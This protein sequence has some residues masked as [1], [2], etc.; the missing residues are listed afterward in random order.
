MWIVKKISDLYRNRFKSFQDL[1]V[2][3]GCVVGIPLAIILVLTGIAAI[4][5]T[6]GTSLLPAL[7]GT[8]L[9]VLLVTGSCASAGNY[10]G[11]SIDSM[12]K[13][14]PLTNAK[15]ATI[16]G[17]IIGVALSIVA[18]PLGFVGVPFI[19]EKATIPLWTLF[20]C[21]VPLTVGRFG[22]ACSYIG[23]AVDTAVGTLANFFRK[24]PPSTSSNSIPLNKE[25]IRMSSSKKMQRSQS[26]SD[27]YSRIRPSNSGSD[28][29][30]RPVAGDAS[31]DR[32]EKI[33]RL[34]EENRRLH[35][36]LGF[37]PNPSQTL[38]GSSVAGELS[39]RRRGFSFSS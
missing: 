26:M 23:R 9:F 19:V 24:K 39:Y 4:P 34:K 28:S 16:A 21:F 6:G 32:E 36:G 37:F 25:K 30:S 7:I 1:L 33:G 13:K 15:I 10:I 35:D 31:A 17:C 38:S 5:F 12:I 8:A 22:S 29:D 3:I 18:I 20:L 11:L 2:L 27:L 14:E